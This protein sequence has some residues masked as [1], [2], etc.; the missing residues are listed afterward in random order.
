MTGENLFSLN[1]EGLSA[2]E[3]AFENKIAVVTGGAKGIGSGMIR[4]M[5]CH[6]DFGRKLEEQRNLR[7][8]TKWK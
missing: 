5:I 4:Q 2:V 8:K 7:R 6:N 1:M 3:C